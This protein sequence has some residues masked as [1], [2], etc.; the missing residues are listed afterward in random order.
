[1]PVWIPD[2]E[3]S[4]RCYCSVVTTLLV[5]WCLHYAHGGYLAWRRDFWCRPTKEVVSNKQLPPAT[6]WEKNRKAILDAA[7]IHKRT[8]AFCKSLLLFKKI[9]AP[10]LKRRLSYSPAGNIEE[11]ASMLDMDHVY[12]TFFDVSALLE[13]NTQRVLCKCVFLTLFFFS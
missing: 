6:M 8:F 1:M 3:E 7:A 11:Q 5:V 10:H 9:S 12:M 2:S 4:H 13:Y